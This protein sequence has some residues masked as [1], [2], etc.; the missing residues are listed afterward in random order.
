M[1]I[2]KGIAPI[3]AIALIALVAAG[4]TAT[5]YVATNDNVIIDTVSDG[6]IKLSKT[7]YDSE[8]I[9]SKVI[10]MADAEPL[11]TG[12]DFTIS[13]D[14]TVYSGLTKFTA[15]CNVTNNLNE[16]VKNKD[17]SLIFCSLCYFCLNY[18]SVLSI[19]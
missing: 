1:V 9:P 17:M 13:C 8:T 16:V 3:I 12:D 18:F 6:Q 5:Y 11:V 15:Y 4:A 2:S 19:L 7:E 10:E 14:K